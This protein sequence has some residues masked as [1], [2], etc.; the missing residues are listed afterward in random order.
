MKAESSYPLP[1]NATS[2]SITC[3][4][5]GATTVNKDEDITPE[6]TNLME[7]F[8]YF[9][10]FLTEKEDMLEKM[11]SEISAMRQAA[12]DSQDLT[13]NALAAIEEKMHGLSTLR[14]N[15]EKS[16]SE[17]VD[18]EIAELNRSQEIIQSDIQAQSKATCALAKDLV[19]YN[20]L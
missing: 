6:F 14:M 8:A 16:L 9:Y 12:T 3:S 5:P 11:N 4:G 10:N 2:S 1:F 15:Y 13:K 7:R 20:L 17:Y 19:S 18:H